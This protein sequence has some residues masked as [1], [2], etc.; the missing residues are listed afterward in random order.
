[1]SLGS[2]VAPR[3]VRVNTELCRIYWRIPRNGCVD[4]RVA[5]LLHRAGLQ[6]LQQLTSILGNAI[7]GKTGEVLVMGLAG[8]PF[9][10]RGFILS[11]AFRP[12]G[13]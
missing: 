9:I 2:C 11:E 8:K 7:S 10:S 1:M 4:D 6:G 5:H 3:Y 13:D 12:V